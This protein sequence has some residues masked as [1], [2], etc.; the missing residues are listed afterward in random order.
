MVELKKIKKSD[1]D[2]DDE[3][4]DNNI[5]DNGYAVEFLFFFK[6]KEY[7]SILECDTSKI[8]VLH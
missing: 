6:C 1:K 3:E 7:F 4:D 5:G 2:N 8:L